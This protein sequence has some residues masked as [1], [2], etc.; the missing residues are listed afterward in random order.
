[1][2]L[3]ILLRPHGGVRINVHRAEAQTIEAPRWSDT[4]NAIDRSL[5]KREH[6]TAV[7]HQRRNVASLWGQIDPVPLRERADR[8]PFN[9]PSRKRQGGGRYEQARQECASIHVRILL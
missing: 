4:I 6:R 2:K 3:E 7:W 8:W 9:E 5:C 1:M